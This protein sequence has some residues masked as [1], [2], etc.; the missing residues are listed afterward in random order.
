MRQKEKPVI[1]YDSRG[2]TGNIYWILGE[3]CQIMR[4]RSEIIAYNEI[5]DRVF[6]A[7]SYEE[8]LSIIG[9]KATLIDI[10]K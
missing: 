10:R 3:L 8:A 2:R 5:R 1:R 6:D 7:S 9:E 4:K